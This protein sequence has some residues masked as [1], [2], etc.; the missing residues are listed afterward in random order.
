MYSSTQRIGAVE[1]TEIMVDL[2]PKRNK[3]TA[4][5]MMFFHGAGSAANYCLD[6][7]PANQ[8][9]LT[10]RIAGFWPAV[11]GL[12]G[13]DQWGNPDS[14]TKATD[15]FNHLQSRNAGA[16]I[17]NGWGEICASMG[18]L[19]A[20][21]FARTQSVKP[22]A[23]VAVIPCI[24]LNDIVTNDRGGF[25][26][27]INTSY[28]GAYNESTDGAT[29]NPATYQADA[30]ITGIPMLIFYGLTDTICLPEYTEAFIAADSANRTGVA[31]E[32]GHDFTSY[33]SVDQNMVL[34]FLTT[35]LP[36]H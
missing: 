12:Y 33:N 3:G 5:G 15:Y 27:E 16:P 32:S 21:N 20:L 28:G 13:G 29:S 34:D 26:S 10:A 11:S 22:S 4:S 25:A 7:Y 30:A 1:E 14:V 24:N 23:I 18:G 6:A 31:L 8:A 36:N 17:A 2:Y 35:H 9:P 19:T